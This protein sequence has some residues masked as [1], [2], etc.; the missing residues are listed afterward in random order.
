M[1]SEERRKCATPSWERWEAENKGSEL[2]LEMQK[3]MDASTSPLADCTSANSGTYLSRHELG[4]GRE[5][6]MKSPMAMY[7][8]ARPS[9]RPNGCR[10]S[11]RLLLLSATYY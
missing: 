3:S 9:V 5:R 8:P 4:N 6:L 2:R 7:L 11:L 10:V 1:R